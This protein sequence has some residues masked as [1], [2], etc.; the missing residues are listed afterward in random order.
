MLDTTI[1]VRTDNFDGP[2]A[3]LLLLIQKEEM[4]IKELELTKITGQYL[5]YLANMKSLDF[6]VAGDYLFL[7]ATLLLLKSKS[8][9]SDPELD[10]LGNDLSDSS[11]LE[12][13]SQA[14]LIKRLEELKHFQ[15]LGEKLWGLPKMGYEVFSKPK[16]NRKALVNS[17]LTP[18]DLEK[19]TL[20]MID[21]MRKEKRKYSV[22]RRDRLSIKEKL[23][24]LKGFLQEGVRVTFQEVVSGHEGHED[25]GI[26]NVV[27]TFISLLELA[28]LNK[29][30]IFQN[31]ANSE[32]YVEV[33]NSLDNFD[34][35]LAD[36]F[37]EEDE[38]NDEI[39]IDITDDGEIIVGEEV[40]LPPLEENEIG[41]TESP[42]LQ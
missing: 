23:I 4:D 14:E 38:E 3:L 42:L 32:I 5:D 37:E 19:L 2:L 27:I 9:I 39:K 41:E 30:S 10:L 35:D 25:K 29:I 33:N 8:A 26:I 24:F 22:I 1:Q 34:V 18:M 40:S 12:I 36:G 28:R 21:L 15:K 7:A 13:T 16:V 17:I 11:L 20:S 31:E 6:D